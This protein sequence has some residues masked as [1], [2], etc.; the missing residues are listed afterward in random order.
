MKDYDGDGFLEFKN[1]EE[2]T[3]VDLNF[4]VYSGSTIKVNAAKK[5][6]EDM[7]S[8]GLQVTVDK[9]DWNNYKS[10]STQATS[11]DM[12]YCGGAPKRRL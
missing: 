4:L 5:V 11:D 7:K 6:A 3:K 10:C 1:G 9:Q 12:A 8:I 2:I